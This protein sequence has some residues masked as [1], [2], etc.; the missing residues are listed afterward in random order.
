MPAK[1]AALTDIVDPALKTGFNE[2]YLLKAD[3]LV[4]AA[5]AERNIAPL[6]IELPNVL[7]TELAVSH[8]CRLACVD[9]AIAA[10]SP[11]IPKAR[12]YERTINLLVTG[13]TREALGLVDPSADTAS[14]YG[15]FSLGRS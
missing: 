2:A 15:F 5:L 11:M 9:K 4:D 12:E 7:L 14:G 13:L 10:D 8:A 1:Y 3:I 6:D